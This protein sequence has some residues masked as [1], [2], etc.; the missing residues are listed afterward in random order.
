MDNFNS[1]IGPL[2]IRVTNQNESFISPA[3]YGLTCSIILSLLYHFGVYEKLKDDLNPAGE[4]Y[5]LIQIIHWKNCD[6]R[7]LFKTLLSFLVFLCM[8]PIIIV[9]LT[10]C[11]LRRRKVHNNIK[12]FTIQKQHCSDMDNLFV[13]EKIREE[14]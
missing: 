11:Y 7:K 10:I 6:Y 14:V 8:L 1:T 5:S 12:V 13:L 2:P 3:Q 9:T 4:L